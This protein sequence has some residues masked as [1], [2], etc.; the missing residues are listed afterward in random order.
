[1]IS[2]AAANAVGVPRTGPR[3]VVALGMVLSA[4]AMG[5]FAQ[6]G[7]HS[8]YAADLLPASVLFGVGLGMVFAPATDFAIRGVEPG[9]AG[10]ASGLVNATNQVGG[11]LGLALLSTLATT[12][13]RHY[14]TGKKPSPAVIAHAGV[15]GYTTGFWWAAGFFVAGALITGLLM[16]GPAQQPASETQAEADPQPA[17]VN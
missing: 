12:A 7:V 17:G 8:T 10:V 6:L 13:T 16:R 5:L 11:S 2:S 14:L 4:I 9:D 15:H 1:M 3:P